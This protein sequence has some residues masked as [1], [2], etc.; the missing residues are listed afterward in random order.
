MHPNQSVYPINDRN[1][2]EYLKLIGKINNSGPA[3][4]VHVGDIGRSEGTNGEVC[5]D[6][7]LGKIK[8]SFDSFTAPLI[9]TPGDN[10]WLNCSDKQDREWT[11]KR[12]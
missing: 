2:S 7:Y 3:F 6:D 4:T 11:Q 1:F 5:S 8:A 12:T 10:E 9:Y